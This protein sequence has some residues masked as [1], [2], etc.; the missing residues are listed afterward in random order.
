MESDPK[1]LGLILNGLGNAGV[2]MSQTA[3]GNAGDAI[4]I[5]FALGVV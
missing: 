3:H 5:L 2:T 4:E 1:A